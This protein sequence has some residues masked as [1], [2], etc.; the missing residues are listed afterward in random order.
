MS[1]AFFFFFSFSSPL[2]LHRAFSTSL[3][4]G[5]SQQKEIAA[6]KKSEK[7]LLHS[8]KLQQAQ[9]AQ[10]E[11]KLSTLTASV[12]FFLFCSIASS[13]VCFFVLSPPQVALLST[14]FLES[15]SVDNVCSKLD[16]ARHFGAS[17]SNFL[18]FVEEH[19]TKV[20]ASNGRLSSVLLFFLCF[21][22]FPPLF[23]QVS[24]PSLVTV[25]RS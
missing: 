25:L 5:Q 9:I 19:A 3:F 20:F 23:P 7:A 13:H 10:L 2:A 1:F 4:L 18:P 8:E 6:L 11:S 16:A 22:T 15:I 17:L 24:N 14:L 12:R 21:V